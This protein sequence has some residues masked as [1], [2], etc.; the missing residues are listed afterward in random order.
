M[1]LLIDRLGISY[2]KPSVKH[3]YSDLYTLSENYKLSTVELENMRLKSAINQYVSQGENVKTLSS[4]KFV[5]WL[6]RI[7]NGILNFLDLC[8]RKFFD[9]RISKMIRKI[10]K[11]AKNNIKMS[12]EYEYPLYINEYSRLFKEDMRGRRHDN[13]DI[14]YPKITST[15][16]YIAHYIKR[17]KDDIKKIYE[18]TKSNKEDATIDTP[19]FKFIKKNNSMLA[20]KII[21]LKNLAGNANK[22]TNY[23]FTANNPEDLVNFEKEFRLDFLERLDTAY[24]DLLDNFDEVRKY[25][26]SILNE[27]NKYEN[28]STEDNF[29]KGIFEVSNSINTTIT[30]NY[31][32]ICDFMISVLNLL[33]VKWEKEK[34]IKTIINQKYKLERTNY[35]WIY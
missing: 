28:D 21:H 18:F 7:W 1:D 27:I 16:E 35:K 15:F 25:T 26:R 20:N 24:R 14:Y 30:K 6:K 13:D 5:I 2:N 4:N 23:T 33:E 31:K 3:K 34:P 19:N 17:N 12:K 11:I 8:K 32:D 9:L 29:L 22:G 10:E